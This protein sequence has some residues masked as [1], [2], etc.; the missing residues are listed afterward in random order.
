MRRVLLAF[1]AKELSQALRD[2]RM[3][4]LLFIAPILQITLFGCAISTEIRNIRLASFHAPDD[5]EARRLTERFLSSGWFLPVPAQGSDPASLIDAGAADAVLAFPAGGLTRAMGRGEGEV[6]LLVEATNATKA[7]AVEAYARSILGAAGPPRSGPGI[8]LDVRV[9]YNPSMESSAFMVPGVMGMIICLVTIVL[10]SMSL[11]R[12]KETGTFETIIA[13][14][15]GVGEIL[16]GKTVPF[17]LLGLADCVLVLLAGTALFSVPSRGPLWMLALASGVFVATTV[18]VGT[19]ISTIARNQSQA[20]LGSFM[21]LFP[22]NLLSGIMFPV[23]NMPI[24]VRWVAYLDPL[25]YFVTLVRNIM[26]KGG[27]PWVFASNVAVLVV[28]A[29]GTA[30]LSYI[31]FRRT[32]E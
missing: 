12:E 22:A 15:L 26:L 9:L 1:L 25:K 16:L 2:P 21:F 17:V 10:T 14:P 32:L 11:A 24:A 31:R 28:M 4:A 3:R 30:G 8:G 20:M 27:D 29:A 6:Q 5:A 18:S 13:A 19:L 7:R 23:E